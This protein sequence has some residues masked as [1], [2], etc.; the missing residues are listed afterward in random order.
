LNDQEPTMNQERMSTL[1][2]ALLSFLGGAVLGAIVVALTTP[3]SGPQVREDLRALGRRAKDKAG[4]LGDQ[5][6]EVWT[7]TKDRTDQSMADL[8]RGVHEAADDFKRGLHEASED[9]KR[10]MHEAATD[11]LS[12]AAGRIA[13]VKNGVSQT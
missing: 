3:K 12:G 7:E 10:G 2:V 4:N 6:G 13:E 9:L 11:L 5:A 8:K 1:N